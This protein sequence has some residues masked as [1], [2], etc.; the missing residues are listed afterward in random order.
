MTH[1]CQFISNSQDNASNCWK[2]FTQ[3]VS[4]NYNL[5][6]T[7]DIKQAEWGQGYGTPGSATQQQKLGYGR[8][9][10]EGSIIWEKMNDFIRNKKKLF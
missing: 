8:I 3:I 2:W 9:S 6:G 4:S 10:L 1:S 5:S 7:L